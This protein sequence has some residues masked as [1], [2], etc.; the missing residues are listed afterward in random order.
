MKK[1]AK[2]A[3]LITNLFEDI[4]FTSP[5]EALEEAGHTVI[6]ID[7]EGNKSIRGKQGEVRVEIDHGIGDVKPGDFDALFIPGG[8]SPDLLRDDDRVVAF[9]KA[10]MKEMKPVFAICHG[11]QILI[12]AR[13][14]ED[15]DVTGYKSIQVDLE[16]AGAKFY[17]E[18]VIVCQKQLVTSRT[19]KDLPAFNREIVNLLKEKDL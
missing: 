11:P 3:T 12:T 19:P 1:L 18:E 17:D 4:E 2:V 7:K 9:A 14:L 10:F 15:R 16:N 8:F 13:S 6:T 5:K